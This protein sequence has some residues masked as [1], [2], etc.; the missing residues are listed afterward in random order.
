M[1][2][3]SH[4]LFNENADN[5]TFMAL[6]EMLSIITMLSILLPEMVFPKEKEERT[7]DIML[8]MP[9]DTRV[10]IL[11]KSFSQVLIIFFGYDPLCGVYCVRKFQYADE[12]FIPG[13]F[14]SDLLLHFWECT[15]VVR[16]PKDRQTLLRKSTEII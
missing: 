15:L 9:V 12:R 2:L 3:K 6:S 1:V 14:A 11:A 7:W 10:T 4:K 13:V 5:H 8:L 16:F